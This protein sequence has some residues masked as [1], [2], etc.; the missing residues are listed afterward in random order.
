MILGQQIVLAVLLRPLELLKYLVVLRERHRAEDVSENQDDLRA[1]Q[2]PLHRLHH[3]VLELVACL[4]D[5]PIWMSLC[6]RGTAR[7]VSR[8]DY[9]E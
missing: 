2:R 6:D 7:S 3:G 1:M 9:E 4:G 5:D 8:R